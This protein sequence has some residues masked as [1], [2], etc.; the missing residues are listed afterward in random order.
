MW[1]IH[2]C[3]RISKFP[4]FTNSGSRDT[5]NWYFNFD[6]TIWQV[7]SIKMFFDCWN[8]CSI[9]DFIYDFFS[10]LL[11]FFLC[12]RLFFCVLV[13]ESFLL[14]NKSTH[15]HL[16]L[17]NQ[18]FFLFQVRLMKWKT[19]FLLMNFQIKSTS[20][21]NFWRISCWKNRQNC[22]KH[23]TKKMRHVSVIQLIYGIIL[24]SIFHLNK[25]R[26]LL[27]YARPVI[28]SQK[29]RSFGC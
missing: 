24:P 25:F 21:L 6:L 14:F 3:H 16:F 27:A 20:H 29:P 19:W 13:F 18:F 28:L 2:F 22:K 26:R 4:F 15:L 10:F 12:V 7:K 17:D 1:K 9:G 23:T 5:T 11:C 8:K